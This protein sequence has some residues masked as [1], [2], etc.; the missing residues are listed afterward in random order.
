MLN[1]A[2]QSKAGGREDLAVVSVV[3]GTRKKTSIPGTTDV[4][5]EATIV[6]GATVEAT[7][8]TE[9]STVVD[10]A[11]IE[12]ATVTVKV[13]ARGAGIAVDTVTVR[14]VRGEDTVADEVDSV[15]VT[16]AVTVP[17]PREDDM[18]GLDSVEVDSRITDTEDHLRDPRGISQLMRLRV[19]RGVATGAERIVPL[20]V[21]QIPAE[22]TKTNDDMM[23]VV[24]IIEE[25]VITIAK[26]RGGVVIVES[27]MR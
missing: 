8:R 5:D 24:N 3:A 13:E 27:M 10:E 23:T 4:M 7:A 14:A 2:G 19:H 21:V 25:V 26:E 12:V 1:E 17:N 16:V 11:D 6:R 20:L 9:A 22:D 15:V 18:A